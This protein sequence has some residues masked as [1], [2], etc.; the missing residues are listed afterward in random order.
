[1]YIHN[2]HFVWERFHVPNEVT[3]YFLLNA[4]KKS[5]FHP[6]G[7][8]TGKIIDPFVKIFLFERGVVLFGLI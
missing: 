8:T 1:M 6:I 3:H 4:K 7:F 5:S 2:P